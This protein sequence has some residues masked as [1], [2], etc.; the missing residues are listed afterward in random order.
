MTDLER[1]LATMEYS[2]PD[3]V[4]NY[5]LGVWQQTPVRWVT[6][7]MPEGELKFDWFSKESYIGLDRREFT[8][9][10]FGMMPPYESKVLERTERYEIIQ[11]PTGMIT[12]ALIEG[13]V[14]WM[15]MCMDQYLSWVVKD[16][17]DFRKLKKRFV[18]ALDERYPKDWKE[19]LLPGWKNRDYPLVLGHNCAPGGFYWRARDWM[20]TENVS[21]AWYDQPDLMHDMMEFYADFT[22]ACARPI[23]EE[24]TVEYFNLNEDFAMKTGPL[25]GPDTFRTFIFPHLKRLVEFFKSH[26][27]RYVILDSDGN[28]ETLIPLLMDAGIDCIWPLERASDM[29]PM[30]IRRKFGKSLRI[31][32]GVDKRELAKDKA[33]IEAHLKSLIPI[34]EDGGFIPTVDHTVPPDVPWDNFLYYMELKR[35]LLAGTL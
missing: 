6:E 25:L 35:K 26:G 27:T 19:K 3:R 22:I 29:D 10:N 28:P 33:A 4:P 14:G 31:M 18:A 5:E 13:Q 15:R 30:R 9:V 21:Y 8:P 2:N 16:H 11:H 24:T 34:V 1:F 20:G 23:L 12:K 32:G 17:N 7:G